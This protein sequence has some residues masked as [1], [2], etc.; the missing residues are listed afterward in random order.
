M[1]TLSKSQSLR[2]DNYQWNKKKVDGVI[3][4]SHIA[5]VQYHNNALS[6]LLRNHKAKSLSRQNVQSTL[7]SRI[8]ISRII[9]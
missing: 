6:L 3:K 5:I 4:E 1:V 2:T 8:R 9:A 7:P